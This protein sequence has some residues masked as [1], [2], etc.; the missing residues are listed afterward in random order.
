MVC[1]IGPCGLRDFFGCNFME[2]KHVRGYAI[3]RYMAWL[4]SNRGVDTERVDT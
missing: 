4:P 1:L 3:E 2:Q